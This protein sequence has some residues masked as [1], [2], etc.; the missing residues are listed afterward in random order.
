VKVNSR[1]ERILAWSIALAVLIALLGIAVFALRLASPSEPGNRPFRHAMWLHH[2]GP[3]DPV[4][5]QM[6]LDLLRRYLRPG[7]TRHQIRSLLGAPDYFGTRN[8][9]TIGAAPG[10]P[11]GEFD[12]TFRNG[13]LVKASRFACC[14]LGG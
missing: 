10:F 3:L 1:R 8:S 13:R 7:M 5:G 9:Y 6:S 2:D 11:G 12:L 4:R 14:A